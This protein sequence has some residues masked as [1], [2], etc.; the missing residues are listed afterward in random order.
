[1]SQEEQKETQGVEC[2][3]KPKR[4]NQDIFRYLSR[5]NLQFE[6]QYFLRLA[7]SL[8]IAAE[9]EGFQIIPEGFEPSEG[10]NPSLLWAYIVTCSVR[11][12]LEQTR[13]ETDRLDV[14]DAET[15]K[16][17]MPKI[18]EFEK[19]IKELQTTA[20]TTLPANH[21]PSLDH[22]SYEEPG[23]TEDLIYDLIDEL[24][25]FKR[26]TLDDI[27]KEDLAEYNYRMP[28]RRRKE[29]QKNQTQ[30][31]AVAF[32][33]WLPK[34]FTDRMEVEESSMRQIAGYRNYKSWA[35]S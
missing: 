8:D 6:D 14:I 32:V 7:T 5:D 28:R 24:Q 18:E 23:T 10:M 22:F 19:A 26:K 33:G 25:Y 15:D 29:Q 12:L 31:T 27:I 16:I 35:V 9:Y 2:N 17:T 21:S 20:N 1:M 11:F 30:Q 4:L 13:S 34:R 3:D